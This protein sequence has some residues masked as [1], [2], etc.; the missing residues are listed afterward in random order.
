MTLR[1]T[2]LTEVH[3]AAGAKLADFGGWEMP[4]EYPTG[5]VAE[6]AAVRTGAGVFDVS[7]MG[8]LLVM[9]P[10]AAAELNRVF[11]N[12]LDRIGGGQAQYSMLCNDSGGVV[13]DLIIYRIDDHEVRIVPN[14]ANAAAVRDVLA[15]ALPPM[16]TVTDLH[17]REGIL[18]IQGP[19]S[20]RV[21]VSL[22]LLVDGDDLNFMGFR[23]VHRQGEPIVVCRTG[24]TGEHGYE[25]IVR[26]E[27]LPSLWEQ[28]VA[29]A[30][31]CGLGA[32]DTLRTEMGYPLHGQ[33]LTAE[34]S[35]VE[36]GMSWA[37]G[38]DK[39]AFPG[40]AAL[41]AQRAEGRSRALRGLR[42][43]GR[44]VPRPQMHVLDAKGH[45]TG[46]TTSGTFSP[47][48]RTGIALALVDPAL[49]FGDDVA[50]DIRGRAVPATVVRLPFV[51]AAPK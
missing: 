7:H 44:G 30:T 20:R 8:K 50:V 26:S 41:V 21:L 45:R 25:L 31:P 14:A 5:V 24:Y 1:T 9:G 42:L 16:I 39:P 46:I 48:L 47:T 29:V 15:A 18:A 51:D 28:V 12:D 3:R 40:R 34:I 49:T 43:T 32:R 4:I 13:D 38:W 23:V 27:S 6:H 35:P 33:D 37:I 22:G 10:G 19:D 17:D 11:V 36:A 2:P